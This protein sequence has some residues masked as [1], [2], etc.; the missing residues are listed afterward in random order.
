MTTIPSNSRHNRS[1]VSRGWSTPL[2]ALGR[3]R[4]HSRPFAL[5]LDRSILS[6]AGLDP[7]AVDVRPA[8]LDG[9]LS[10]DSLELAAEETKLAFPH[11]GDT[12]AYI[13]LPVSAR[14][15]RTAVRK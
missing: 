8:R 7:S 5:T 1:T 13:V 6:A 9:A 14:S 11:D 4:K 3:G 12:K 15:G 2:G 10:G